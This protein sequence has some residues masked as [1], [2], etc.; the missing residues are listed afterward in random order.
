M[1]SQRSLYWQGLG[2]LTL[3]APFFFLTYGQVNQFT[4]GRENIGSLVFDW[5]RH[6]PF[7]PLT[8]VPY[9]SLDLLYGLSLFACTSLK[10]QRRLVCRLVL[11]SL[12]ACIGFLLF[13]LQFTF[14]RPEI[15]GLAGWLFGQLEQFDLP[16]NQSPSLH[17]ILCWLLW[18]HFHRHLTGIWQKLNTLWFLL[19][20]ISVLTTWQHHFIDVLTGLA[21][22]MVIDWLI[23]DEG[24]WR[25]QRASGK[26]QQLAGRY[27]YGALVCLAGTFLTLW[28]WWPTLALLIVALAYGFLGVDALQKDH[29]GR[30][31]PAAW[32]LLL[33]WRTGMLFSMRLYTRRLPAMNA[34]IDG[35]FLGTYPR[36]PPAQR[37]VLDLTSEFPGSRAL[38][39]GVY[40]CVPMLDLVNPDEASLR[41]A[42]DALEQLRLTQGSV[43][44]HCALGLSRSALVVTA[45]LLQR[46]PEL[47]VTGAVMRVREARP[48]V[49]FT[50]EHMEMLERWKKQVTA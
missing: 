23:P 19:I 7:I 38:Q 18:R 43:L 15:T 28:L 13:P 3:L 49:V 11:A 45:W 32:W 17:I 31:S 42:V 22:G 39:G 50:P 46:Y 14:T 33:P 37:A 4:A 41:V 30:L 47:S 26:R 35:I 1:T 36:R 8:I 48:Q 10:M 27:F 21:L 34:V 5:E 2:W 24:G 12:T 9:W 20:A 25:W 40:Q 16:Y 29:Q 6:I 44:V